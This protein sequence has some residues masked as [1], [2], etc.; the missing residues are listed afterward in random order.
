METM[1]KN[2]Q[3]MV[4]M[5]SIRDKIDCYTVNIGVTLLIFRA[6]WAENIIKSSTHNKRK[7]F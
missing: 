4:I 1:N 2:T 6:C 7:V 5:A 3:K